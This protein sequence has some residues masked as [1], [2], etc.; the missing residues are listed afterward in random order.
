[1]KKNSLTLKHVIQ[2]ICLLVGSIMVVF[3]VVEIYLRLAGYHPKK[4]SIA[5]P[6]LFTNHPITWWTLRPNYSGTVRTLDGIVTYTI[7]SQGVRASHDIPQ[8]APTSRLFIIGDS[9]TFGVG[10]NEE[11]TFP[12]VLNNMFKQQ[13][14][15]TDAVNLGVGGF[16]TFH[17]YERLREYAKLFGIPKI[18]IYMFCPNDPV[19][20][21]EGKKEVVYGIRIDSHRKH[22]RSI[23]FLLDRMYDKWFNPREQKK[24]ELHKQTIE[25][26]NR[27]DVRS[28]IKYLSKLIAWTRQHNVHLLVVITS[29]SQ[30][31][32]P[33]KTFLK[34]NQIP[35]IEARDIFARLNAG[36]QPVSL[37]EG[38]WNQHGH[39]LI[40]PC[41]AE[42]LFQQE[43][44]E[45]ERA[46]FEQ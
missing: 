45:S 27:K 42:Y 31:S 14:I 3:V 30:Y 18:V 5:P 15:D 20:N 1:M 41:I 24:R 16:G 13:A 46:G 6:Y 38:H 4:V 44:V 10:V 32:G 39:Q 36:R 40:A 12:R 34:E 2:N 35:M 22:N 37:L 33:L 29:Y 11:I 28:T 23:A 19:D 43:W 21:I 25:I 9:F 8:N 26:H 7:N 17:S